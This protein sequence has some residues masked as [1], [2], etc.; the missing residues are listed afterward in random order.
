MAPRLAARTFIATIIPV[1]AAIALAKRDCVSRAGNGY[2]IHEV[3]CTPVSR[4]I[5]LRPTYDLRDGDDVRNKDDCDD[6][7]GKGA[8]SN[9]SSGVDCMLLVPAHQGRRPN[10]TC[11][12]R[13]E[14]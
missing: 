14:R 4:E 2:G 12:A 13:V 5:W 8:K 6:A 3:C 7:N 10:I 11:A 9:F 1:K